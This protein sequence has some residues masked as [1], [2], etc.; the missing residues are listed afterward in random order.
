[1][2]SVSVTMVVPEVVLN[3]PP[4]FDTITVSVPPVC[5]CVN[6]PL[7]DSLAL[8]TGSGVTLIWPLV[9]VMDELTVSVAVMVW[10]PA[11]ASVAENV[12][13]PAVK[14]ELA[15]RVADPSVLVKWTVPV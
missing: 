15:G 7:Y 12:L 6:G 13:A 9:P 2:G 10:L 1:M 8:N 14:V 3:A 11:V 5:P 4:V